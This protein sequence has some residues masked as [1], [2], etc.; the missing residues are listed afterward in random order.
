MPTA[1][2]AAPGKTE[3][4]CTRTQQLPQGAPARPT[5]VV[6]AYR[7]NRSGPPKHLSGE[8]ASMANP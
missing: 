3:I 1:R 6:N 4:I 2:P 8:T 7:F 5:I